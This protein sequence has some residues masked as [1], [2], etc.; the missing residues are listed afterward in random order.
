MKST[1]ITPEEYIQELPVNRQEAMIQLRNSILKN[2]PEGFIEVMQYGMIGYVVPHS[3]Y[4]GGYHCDT[5]QPLPF[6]TIASQRNFIAIY[7]MGLYADQD[8]A[9]LV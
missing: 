3:L 6:L 2:L 7:H 4:P 5:K 1:A 8:L 9:K